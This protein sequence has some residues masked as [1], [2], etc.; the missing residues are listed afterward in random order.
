MLELSLSLEEL[1]TFALAVALVVAV[2]EGDNGVGE[3][4]DTDPLPET[5]RLAGGNSD[6]T[7]C[8]TLLMEESMLAV[9]VHVRFAG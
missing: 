2:A 1:V 4:V 5:G 6:W 8:R 9:P 7:A 3:F